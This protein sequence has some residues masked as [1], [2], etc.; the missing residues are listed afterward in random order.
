MWKLP[1]YVLIVL[2][3]V[4]VNLGC[5]FFA[6][7]QTED[8]PWGGVI[9]GLSYAPWRSGLDAASSRHA[10]AA[11]IDADLALIAQ[12]ALNVR[13]YGTNGGQELVPKLAARH[14]LGVTLGIWIGRDL[15]ANE[16]EIANGIDLANSNANVSRVIVG[17]ESLLR[18]DV[19]GSQLIE[20]IRRVQRQVNIPVATAE[21]WHVWLKYPE[22]A[23]TVDFLGIHILPYWEGI[24][25][26]TALDFSIHRY[27]DIRKLYPDKHIYIG[28]IGWP[29]EGQWQQGAEPSRINQAK[30]IRRFL[31]YATEKQLDYSIIEAFDSHWKRSLEGSVGAH[32]GLWDEDHDAKF[33]MS[34]AVTE[35]HNWQGAFGIATLL[36]LGPM[37]WFLRRHDNLKFGGQL[38]YAGLIQAVASVLVWAVL[39]AI[40][41]NIITSTSLAWVVLI[42]AQLVLL[43]V[44]L[45][46]GYELTEV[47]WSNR[48]QRNF[49]PHDAQ[50]RPD[51]PKVS[52]HVPCYNEPPHMVIET[53][54]ALSILNYP[55]FEV[56]VIDNNTKDE[57]VWKP[58][59]EHCALLGPK[60]RFFHLPKWPGYKAGALNF[61]LEQTAPDATIVGVIDSDYVVSPDWLR[62]TV[63]YFDK[64][65]VAFVQA[66]QDYRD[67]PGDSFKTMCNWEYAGFFH[68]GM[69]QR[70][71][72]NA[73]IQHGT[74]TLMQKAALKQVGGWSEW[75]ICE[76]AE[77]GLRLF[78]AGY[79]SVYL[80]HSLGRGLIPDSFA[81]YKTQRFR[82]AYGAV[83][84]IKRHLSALLPGGEEL[85]T[86]QRYHFV[87]GWLPW[88]ADAANMVFAL[89]AVVWSI[90]LALKWVE[91]PPAVFLIPTLS[92]FAFK[93]IAGFWLY[94]RRIKCS[95]RDRFGAALA[96]M[97]LTHTVGRA[98]WQGLFTSGKPFFRTPKCEDKPAF[99]QGILMAREELALLVALL[100]SVIGILYQYSVANQNAVLWAAMLLV[101]S[102]PYWAALFV[103]MVNALPQLRRQNT[104]P[105]MLPAP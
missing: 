69:V 41:E 87:S 48:W 19:S 82:W 89:A 98:V 63:P 40:V 20:Y 38:F 47:V 92:A 57:A 102:L 28:E 76:D 64:P 3:I 104:A 100:V 35:R 97:A 29:S 7:P 42:L 93:V 17:N 85:T 5:W 8:E 56:L 74:M 94:S 91:F 33:P 16:L 34:G 9:T 88:F 66:P 61:A 77:L 52:I 23:Q 68:I 90:L 43:A 12:H 50:P 83:Q 45:V 73:I 65:E 86:G 18:D 6:N 62:A 96:G 11:A 27:E 72:R 1:R 99:M 26:D 2:C 10:D 78:A 71:E 51:A 36:A 59:E 80:A 95:W 30:F 22:L 105:L 49:L 15:A 60:F 101:Q 24:P 31:N 32:W 58:L 14:N 44:L 84:I 81:G 37:L 54:N 103:S 75:C 67:W 21:P 39:A 46:D 70:N 25:V 53:L 79:E 13:T 55:N 4:A